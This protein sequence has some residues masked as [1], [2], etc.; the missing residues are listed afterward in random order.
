MIVDYL[1]ELEKRDQVIKQ[2]L[3]PTKYEIKS[4]PRK[5]KCFLCGEVYFINQSCNC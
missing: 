1:K 4:R 2:M 3:A 5:I